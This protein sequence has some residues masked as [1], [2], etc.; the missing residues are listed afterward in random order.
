MKPL[1]FG[2]AVVLIL[3]VAQVIQIRLL[4]VLGYALLGL[5]IFSFVWARLSLRWLEVSRRGVTERAQV[6]EIYEE[7]ITIRNRSFLPKLWLEIQDGSDLPGHR[8]NCVQSAGPFATIKWRSRTT[9]TLRGRFRLGPMTIT[10]GDPFGIFRF[11]REFSETR[12]LTVYPAAFDINSFEALSGLLQGGKHIRRP[13]HHT[14][15]D[16]NGLRDYRPGDGLNRIHWPSTARFN[17]L[18]VKE[19]E[20]D[21]SV[22]VEIFLDM[23]SLPHWVINHSAGIGAKGAMPAASGIRSVDSTEEY[24]VT[25]AATLCRHYIEARRSV[26][27][28]AWG[29]HKEIISPDRGERQLMKLM[30]ALAVIRAQGKSNFGQV[31]AAEIARL[32]NTDTVILITPSVDER[33]LTVLPLL[34]RKNIKVAVVL[35]EPRTFGAPVE[36]SMITVGTLSAMNTPVYLI[37]RGDDIGQ[38]L[39]SELARLTAKMP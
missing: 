8:V 4:M 11:K 30:E 31:I 13:T 27:L 5:L 28:V 38:S 15:P 29:Q 33:W 24:A 18:I 14:T 26:G 25:A 34:V 16:I 2:I 23:D 22:D 9:C 3:L 21:P 20:F 39:D 35:V 37:K 10:A 12:H 36:N 6:G 19:F 32:R 1:R 17:K 7:I